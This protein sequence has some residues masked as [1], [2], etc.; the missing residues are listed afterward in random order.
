MYVFYAP[1]H[2]FVGLPLLARLGHP[3]SFVESV[4]YEGVA[5]VATFVL[6]ALSY[7]FYEKH[8]LALKARFA[9]VGAS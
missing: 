4:A 8:F 7:H 5:I 3:P 9:P 1:L 6:G 2:L